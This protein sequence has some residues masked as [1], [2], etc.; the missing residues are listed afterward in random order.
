M[1]PASISLWDGPVKANDWYLLILLL[2]FLFNILLMGP[3]RQYYSKGISTMFR[4]NSPE[5]DICFPPYSPMGYILV[6]LLSCIDMGLGLALVISDLSEPGTSML[7]RVLTATGVPALFFAFK[8][9]LYRIVNSRLYKSQTIML[10]TSRWNGFFIMAFSAS[11]FCILVLSSVVLFFELPPSVLTVCVFILLVLAQ[12]GL[13]F[14]L[15]TS[16]FKNRCSTSRFIL[17]LCALE[18][19]PVILIL[20]LLAVNLYS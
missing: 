3:Y 1:T 14:K 2:S 13:I 17:Y 7:Y 11:G 20:V 4:F 5:A 12:T 18:L 15:K 16:L 19:G 8:I 9:L 6:V 10:K